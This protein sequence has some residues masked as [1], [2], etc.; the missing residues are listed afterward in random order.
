ESGRLA[1]EVHVT[2]L[3][4]H[5]RRM[6]LREGTG[7]GDGELLGSFI[8]R[9]DESALAALIH[10]HASMVWGV[11]RRLL[12]HHDADDAFQAT[13]LVLDR[14][15]ASIVPRT[16]VANWL[17]G[18]AHQTA[19]QARRNTARRRTREVQVTQMPDVEA[20]QKDMWP[21]LQ[22]VLDEELSRLP[23]I[24]RAVVV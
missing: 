12:A 14:K 19:L 9:R 23:D 5:F 18:V 20:V 4:E 17:Y 6:A 21:D 7:P 2:S 13:F 22:P 8:E 1:R 24:Y 10:R 3:T 16:M 15:A 11:C